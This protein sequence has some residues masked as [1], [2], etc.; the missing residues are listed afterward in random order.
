MPELPEQLSVYAWI[1]SYVLF[2]A[3]ERRFG[4]DSASGRKIKD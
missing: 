4:R 2:V 1:S 3:I